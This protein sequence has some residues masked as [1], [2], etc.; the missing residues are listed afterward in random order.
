[1]M[2]DNIYKPLIV[3]SDMTLL[4]E[5]NNESYDSAR[6]ELAGFAEPASTASSQTVR[7]GQLMRQ[8]SIT[9]A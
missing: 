8:A 9:S 6:D 4:L 5:T 7:R 1:M 2:T 3:Q